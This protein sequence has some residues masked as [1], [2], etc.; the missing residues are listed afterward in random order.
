MENFYETDGIIFR[1]NESNKTIF[2]K[3]KIDEFKSV[4]E[5]FINEPFEAD[6]FEA[7][8]IFERDDLPT[9]K[10]CLCSKKHLEHK[11]YYITHKKSKKMFCVG[12]ECVK[13]VD[14]NLFHAMR[15][16][17]CKACGKGIPDKRYTHA[18]NGYCSWECENSICVV[19]GCD[20]LKDNP[21]FKFCK[22]CFLKNNKNSGKCLDCDKE[23]SVNFKRCFHCNNKHKE[24]FKFHGF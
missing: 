11:S 3:N 19:D 1:D 24:S 5:S 7:L 18:Q 20:N 14:L 23:I 17:E 6:N 8:S 9:N 22:E 2:G 21:N 16:G 4:L 10:R 15:G 12:A 13:K